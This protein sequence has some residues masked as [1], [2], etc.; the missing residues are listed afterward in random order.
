MKI[1]S[2]ETLQGSGF[3]LRPITADDSDLI[4]AASTTDI[5]DW[6]YI[7]RNLDQAT[8]RSW[9]QRG[10]PARENGRAIRFVIQLADGL[11][12][13][14]GAEHLY[15]HD[16]GIVETFYFIL[17]EYRRRGLAT[18]SLRQIDEWLPQVTPELRRL[19]L[20]VIVGNPG[21]GRV[22]ERAGYKYEGVAVNQIPAVNGFGPRDAEVYATAITGSRNMETGGVLA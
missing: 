14:V 12:G 22:A 15:G 1:S 13:T 3:L 6:T 21:S 8:A 4:V 7:P 2:S 9:I 10:L 17:P 20:H 19:Q 16:P 11:A 5:P 18:A